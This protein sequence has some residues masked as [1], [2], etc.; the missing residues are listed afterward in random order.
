LQELQASQ[1]QL[2]QPLSGGINAGISGNEELIKTILNDQT[3]LTL[4]N[5]DVVVDYAEDKEDDLDDEIKDAQDDLAEERER[6]AAYNTDLVQAGASGD[7]GEI[8]RVNDKIDRT[9]DDIDDLEDDIED[10]ED[11][12][13]DVKRL[14][15]KAEYQCRR[16]ERAF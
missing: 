10:L 7:S 4:Q 9:E 11:D 1:Q 3:K 16:L 12:Y 14:R 6:L 15:V 2:Q 5:C 8:R 13:D